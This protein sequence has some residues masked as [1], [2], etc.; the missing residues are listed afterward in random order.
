MILLAFLH[1]GL[2]APNGVARI[3]KNNRIEDSSAILQVHQARK[4]VAITAVPFTRQ[5]LVLG[6]DLGR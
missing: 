6:L 3:I 2:T 1:Q 4:R 5:R